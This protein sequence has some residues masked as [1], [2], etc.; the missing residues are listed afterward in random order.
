MPTC[1]EAYYAK[2]RRI[3]PEL[4]EA[5]LGEAT[6]RLTPLVAL[7]ARRRGPARVAGRARG[8]LPRRQ[9]DQAGRQ[10]A[11]ARP[12]PARASSSAARCWRPTCRATGLVVAMAAELDGEAN[13]IRLMPRAVPAGP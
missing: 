9:A 3:P 4:S 11:Q 12:G 13:D 2:L 6:A 1:Q 5:F 7:F 8:H 10:A